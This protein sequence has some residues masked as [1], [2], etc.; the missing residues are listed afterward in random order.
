MNPKL[1]KKLKFKV[2]LP[3]IK[4][5]CGQSILDTPANRIQSKCFIKRKCLWCGN[6]AENSPRDICWDCILK[7]NKE[8]QLKNEYKK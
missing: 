8:N 5:S 3:T 6:Q 2:S 7:E 4:C 1:F